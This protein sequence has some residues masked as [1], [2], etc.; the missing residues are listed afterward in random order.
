MTYIDLI[1]RVLARLRET[2]VSTP[3][4]TE[5]STLVGYLVNDAKKVVE[6]AWDWSA[7]RTTK[8]VQVTSATNSYT[9]TGS[10]QDYKILDAYNA[11]Q[12]TRLKLIS[13][14][15]MN[16]KI[17]LNTAAVGVPEMFSF[18]GIDSNGDQNIVVYPTPDGSYDLNFDMVI[19][20]GE[21]SDAD[22][23]TKLPS[24]PIIMYAWSFATRERG[25]TGGTAAQ[26]I[27]GIA[28][29]ALADAVSLDAAK[30][31]V[32]LNWRPA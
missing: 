23:V 9:I 19:R 20:E 2:Q 21:L 28:D 32:E 6:T 4:D 25:E 27:F 31:S 7:L 14:N 26:E 17:N 3:T 18:N 1:N 29:R 16:T 24:H 15:E 30:Y 12:K 11:T 22:D 13:T 10:G 8:T 5:Y